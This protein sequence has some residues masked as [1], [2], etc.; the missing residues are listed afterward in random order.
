VTRPLHPSDCQHHKA[1]PH[2]HFRTDSRARRSLAAVNPVSARAPSGFYGWHVVAIAAVILCCTAPGQTAAVSAFIDPMIRDLHVSRS[3]ISTAYLIGTLTGAVAM[4]QVGRLVDRFGARRS[5][6]AVGLFFG[7]VLMSFALVDGV[8]GLTLGFI[9]V[10]TLGQGALGLT[11]TLAASSWFDTRRGVALSLVSAVGA[12]GI[13]TAPLL[14]ERLIGA[15]GWRTAWIVEGVLIWVVVV[16]LAAFAMRDSPDHLGQ[17]TDGKAEHL[18]PPTPPWG[19]TRRDAFREPFLWTVTA[20]VG[21]SGM[22]ST[23]VAFHQI[24]ILGERGLTTAQAAA[25]FLPQTVAGITATLLTG[26]LIDRINPRWLTGSAMLALAAGLVWGVYVTPGWSALGFGMAIGSSGAAIR[27]LEAAVAPR[28]FGTLHLGSI[29]G[30]I[31]AV[32]VGS[33]AFGPLLFAL[34][35]Q[36]TGSYAS[37]LVASALLPLAVMTSALLAKPPRGRDHAPM[38]TPRIDSHLASQ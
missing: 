29:R 13:S 31:A 27:A 10:R 18:P 33:T 1:A 30:F 37:V 3:L 38:T 26:A 12:A 35:H 17:R 25:N 15:H 32:S 20:G 6:L 19:M 24:S 7:A 4:P 22:L 11:A 36:V 14:L 8:V 9:G 28:F 21:V 34:A 16:P 5:M 23:A 2:H